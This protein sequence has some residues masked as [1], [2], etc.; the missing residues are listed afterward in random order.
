MTLTEV[1]STSWGFVEN[2]PSGVIETEEQWNYAKEYGDKCCINTRYLKSF[3]EDKGRLLTVGSWFGGASFYW[4]IS[5]Y[6]KNNPSEYWIKY[7][8]E[9]IDWYWGKNGIIDFTK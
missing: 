7:P 5:E 8:P 3:E 6:D 1:K 4:S 9:H 2:N